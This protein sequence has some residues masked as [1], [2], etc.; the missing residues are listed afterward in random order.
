MWRFS[1]GPG[2]VD[3]VVQVVL[4]TTAGGAAFR[5]SGYVVVP[6]FLRLAISCYCY[7]GRMF[8][9]KE[10]QCGSTPNAFPLRDLRSG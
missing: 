10:G 2:I 6:S 8:R 5:L 1:R 3:R 7:G 9:V 4:L